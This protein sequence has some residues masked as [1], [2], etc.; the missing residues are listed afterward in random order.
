MKKKH[1]YYVFYNAN[2]QGVQNKIV[3]QSNSFE[4]A[5][6]KV[7]LV[8]LY[9]NRIK[10]APIIKRIINVINRRIN[11]FVD[12]S[13]S[14]ELI[15]LGKS[16]K[17]SVIYIR[18]VFFDLYFLRAVKKFKLHNNLVVI[19][20]NS[21]PFKKEVKSSDLQYYYLHLFYKRYVYKYIDFIVSFTDQKKIYNIEN[22]LITNG[23]DVN[24][25]QMK[26]PVALSNDIN[27]IIVSSMAIWHGIDR[28]IRGMADYYNQGGKRNILFH[29]VGDGNEK[30]KLQKLVNNL[31]LNPNVKFYGM[32]F[33]EELS[34]LYDDMH[35]GVGSLGC[36]R[37][38]T[39]SVT[40]L[41][42][43]EYCAKGL[44]F[45]IS[46]N[47]ADM[48]DD[49]K[50]LKYFPDNDSNI[51]M[52]E[53]ISYADKLYEDPNV[54][55]KLRKWAEKNLQWDSKLTPVIDK[56]NALMDKIKE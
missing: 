48:P 46:V 9:K 15:E 8:N 34:K 23:I 49:F 55:L 47:V 5:G 42:T 4:K 19:E 11:P 38:N 30:E 24:Q 13:N 45:M 22:V 44:P 29:I 53:V 35:I 26:K 1:F 18:F 20:L 6:Y 54:N 3:A 43:R 51:D 2:N 21:Y 52:N 56:L 16:V 40:A 33:G 41:K 10:K 28:F 7:T 36:H 27:V 25:I 39:K 50:Y 32:L 14:K 31:E 12:V 17:D 37:V